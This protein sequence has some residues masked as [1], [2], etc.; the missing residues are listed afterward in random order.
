[1]FLTS[2]KGKR[3]KNKGI[4][5]E[6]T[7]FSHI[8]Y[9]LNNINLL[10]AYTHP[11][12]IGYSSGVEKRKYNHLEFCNNYDTID[13]AIRNIRHREVFLLFVE[14]VVGKQA[15]KFMVQQCHCNIL[16]C[17]RIKKEFIIFNPNKYTFYKRC[18]H[19]S[20]PLLSRKVFFKLNIKK[21]IKMYSCSLSKTFIEISY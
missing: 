7:K 15:P 20:D 19:I 21:H 1:M 8:N 4:V 12:V 6:F 11:K 18:H 3:S 2:S 13:E 9:I 16:L 10:G 17:N 14:G 5:N